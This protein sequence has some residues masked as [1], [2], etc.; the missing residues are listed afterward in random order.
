MQEGTAV[1]V[2]ASLH[3]MSSPGALGLAVVSKGVVK[4]ALVEPG[5]L[6]YL[7]N[8]HALFRFD[9]QASSD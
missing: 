2:D 4:L 3:L 9:Y 6:Q 7:L 5:L 1:G 8:G